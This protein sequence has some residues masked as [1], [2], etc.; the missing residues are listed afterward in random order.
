LLKDAT[1][2]PNQ[3]MQFFFHVLSI[4]PLP[5]NKYVAAQALADVTLKN[6]PTRWIAF[7]CYHFLHGFIKRLTYLRAISPKTIAD[8]A[9]FT[10]ALGNLD[11]DDLY[12]PPPGTPLSG[13]RYPNGYLGRGR[14]GS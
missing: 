2:F 8:Q 5:L 10:T 13:F 14:R 6:D 11:L 4:L 7:L 12:A 9:Q 1:H 3:G